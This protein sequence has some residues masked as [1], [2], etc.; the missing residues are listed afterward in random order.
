MN[1][2]DISGAQIEGG[3]IL[4]PGVKE[5]SVVP[6]TLSVYTSISDQV[7]ILINNSVPAKKN[8]LPTDLS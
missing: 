6:V 7:F 2:S 8:K 5:A 1:G 3:L 4:H